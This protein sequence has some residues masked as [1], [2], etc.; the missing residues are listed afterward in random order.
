MAEAPDIFTDE[1]LSFTLDPRAS[2]TEAGTVEGPPTVTSS[3]EAVFTVEQDADNPFAVRVRGA[4]TGGNANIHIV[5]GAIEQ[6]VPLWVAP[7][8]S[9]AEVRFTPHRP[10]NQP[11]FTAD[12]D[13]AFRVH[14][15]TTFAIDFANVAFDGSAAHVDEGTLVVSSTHEDV[16]TVELDPSGTR[17]NVTVIGEGSCTVRVDFKTYGRDF[18]GLWPFSADEVEVPP[19][20]GFAIIN[21]SKRRIA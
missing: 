13:G 20:I 18:Y 8:D 11:K 4:G 19:A 17:I 6:D 7:R 1:E 14:A 12:N 9:A 10:A 21:P 2:E 16:A 3:D 15:P 5:D